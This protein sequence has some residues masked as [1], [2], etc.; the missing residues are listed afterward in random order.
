MSALP[1]WLHARW[2]A[3]CAGIE[4]LPHG[5]LIAG[6]PGVGKRMLADTLAARLLCKAAQGDQAACGECPS[7]HLRLAGNHPDLHLLVPAA[8]TDAPVA[9]ASSK[10]AKPS[11]HIVIEQIRALQS[12]LE[13]SAHMGGRRAVVVE[14][15]EAMNPFT[16]NALLKLLEE[17]PSETHLLLVSANAGQLLPTLRSRCQQWTI[18]PPD[19]EQAS[20]WLDA[21]APAEANTLLDVVGGL[22][23]AA[24]RAAEQGGATALERF[25]ADLARLQRPADAIE[26]A[27]K[28]EAW[29][30]SKDGSAAG[31][32]MFRFADWMQRWVWDLAASAAG[33]PCRYFPAHQAS[34]GQLAASA[35]LP[36]LVDCYNE[37]CKV[38]RSASHP[39]NLR[40]AIEDMLMRYQRCVTGGSN[41]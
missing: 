19:R 18:Y 28:W 16:A 27:G 7:C 39:L 32:D 11:Q 40:L 10:S 5:I 36:G 3:L 9:G 13:I 34:I 6:P 29:A 8:S 2:T 33:R 37:I 14:P 1:P 4:Q 26:V 41:R 24:A 25:V 30:K 15:A 20:A 35:A 31:M 12:A 17:P 22:P 38:R 23:L 21:N